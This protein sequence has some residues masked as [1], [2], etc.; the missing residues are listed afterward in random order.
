GGRRR[1]LGSSDSLHVAEGLEAGGGLLLVLPRVAVPGDCR[2]GGRVRPPPGAPRR[3]GGG[4]RGAPPRP[5]PP[6]AGARPPRP[7][8]DRGGQVDDPRPRDGRPG[9]D[10][11]P[12]AQEDAVVAV[13]A[14]LV[15]EVLQVLGPPGVHPLDPGPGAGLGTE[16]E[17][18]T[19]PF[20]E[21]PLDNDVRR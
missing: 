13:A 3:A 4:A 8:R 16:A 21:G 11:R 17:G 7:G 18:I 14:R 9:A 20:V 5:A 6:R 12:P 1:W 10:P 2:Q 19:V 15:R